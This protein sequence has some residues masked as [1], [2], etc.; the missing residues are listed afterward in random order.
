MAPANLEALV[1]EAR[2]AIAATETPD[3]LT[4]V[5]ARYLGRKGSVAQVLRG[6]GKL[7]AEERA[8]TGEAAN[9]AKASIE[10]LVEA[11]RESLA[12]SA[13]A[14]ALQ[15]H[16]VDVTLPGAGPPAGH[17]HPITHVVRDMVG[18]FASMGFSLEEGPEVETDWHNFEALNL[19][20]EH[21]ARDTQDTFYLEGDAGHL[22]RTQTSNVQI[23][24]MTGK[25]PLDSSELL[26][27]GYDEIC[28]RIREEEA[29]AP[30]KSVP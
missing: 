4:Q 1:E 28:R 18:F 2:A 15:D 20:P 11:H 26:N 8:K 12:R 25:T 23:R 3:A 7:A 22:L 24:V 5:R 27:A 17:L 30:S 29:M 13:T 9:V 10:A 21:P 14:H 19:P 16:Q 6:I